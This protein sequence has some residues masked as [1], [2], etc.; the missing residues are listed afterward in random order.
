MF[1]YQGSAVRR[2][3]AQ[4]EG[5]SGVEPDVCVWGFGG[6]ARENKEL[7]ARV[8]RA[9]WPSQ[10]QRCRLEPGE[11]AGRVGS[12]RWSVQDVMDGAAAARSNQARS[13]QGVGGGARTRVHA[14]VQRARWPVQGPAY[15]AGAGRAG[16][17]CGPAAMERAKARSMRGSRRSR[18]ATGQGPSV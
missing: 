11:P 4:G 13:D 10:G 18:T 3:S 14:R 9:R 15:K 8:R 7:H 5:R 12:S 1:P 6:G 17:A 2:R 16:G